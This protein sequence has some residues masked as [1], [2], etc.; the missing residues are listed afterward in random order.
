MNVFHGGTLHNTGEG[1]V[2]PLVIV[3]RKGLLGSAFPD[4]AE[5]WSGHQQSVKDLAPSLDVVVTSLSGMV[6]GLQAKSHELP[7]IG[8]QFH[9]ESENDDSVEVVTTNRLILDRFILMAKAAMKKT[10]LAIEFYENAA[11]NA[12]RRLDFLSEE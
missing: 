4:N 8:T 5:G 10:C 6:K 7:L 12:C 9:P 1:S 2:N 3:K 11:L